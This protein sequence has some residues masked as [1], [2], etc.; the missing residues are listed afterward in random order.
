MARLFGRRANRTRPPSRTPPPELL[1]EARRQRG[2]W[3][4][5][6]DGAMVSDPD[7]EVPPTAIIG[8]WE[9]SRDGTL[10]GVYRANPNYAPGGTHGAQD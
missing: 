6:I 7:G 8:A 2:G 1:A 10:T 5:E 4:Y 3:V 9:V